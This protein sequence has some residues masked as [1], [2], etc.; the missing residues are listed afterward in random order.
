MENEPGKGTLRKTSYELARCPVCSSS[1]ASEIADESAIQRELEIL[2]SF[3]ARRFRHPVP[4]PYLTDRVVFSQ[5]PPLRL[6]RCT[7]CTHLYRNPRERPETVRKAYTESGLEETVYESLLE[8]QRVACRAQVRRLMAFSK[9]VRRGLEV[10]SYVGGFL[11]A[12]R[13]AGLA[14]EGIDVST[15][16]AAFAARKGLR[17]HTSTLEEFTDGSDYDVIAIWNTFEQLPDVRAAALVSRRLLR[18]GGTLVVRVPNAGFYARWRRR[19]DGPL[20]PIAE[21]LLAHN[22]LLGFPYREGFTARSMTR[23]LNDAGFTI[24]RVHGDTLAPV[25]DR[26][27]RAPAAVDERVTKGIQRLLQRR[28]RA[29]WVDVYSVAR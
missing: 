26:W 10:G 13:E 18:D 16:A 8:N 9:G 20:G 27:T 4:L 28:W 1:D 7:S 21:R 2:W 22:N 25:A 23:L 14:F 29:P 3:H 12:A 11:A 6:M 17:I 5:S 15:A 24:R 19:L